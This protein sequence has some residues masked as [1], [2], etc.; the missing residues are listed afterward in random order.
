M[1][2]QPR[3]APTQQIPTWQYAALGVLGLAVVVVAAYMLFAPKP[4]VAAPPRAAAA[5]ATG[6]PATAA[7]SEAPAE[8]EERPVPWVASEIAVVPGASPFVIKESA[9]LGEAIAARTQAAP[10]PAEQPT[11]PPQGPPPATE[12]PP[13][14]P[15]PPPTGAPPAGAQPPQWD[16]VPPAFAE[17]SEVSRTEPPPATL[18]EQPPQF[19]WGAFRRPSSGGETVY[20]SPDRSRVRYEDP[21][22]QERVG[23]YPQVTGTIVGG[24]GNMTA[25]VASGSSRYF[26]KQGQELEVAGK[27][28]RVLSVDKGGVTLQDQRGGLAKLQA[29][30]GAGQ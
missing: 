7:G 28:M 8:S 15:Q 13:A 11:P 2:K 21:A 14:T 19:S 10:P 18:Q 4:R 22:Q 1:A 29:I 3:R 12:A 26:V 5:P 17:P 9:P 6:Q 24:D 27:R 25:I 23:E 20:R 30:G 16:A